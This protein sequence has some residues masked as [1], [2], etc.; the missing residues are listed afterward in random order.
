MGSAQRLEVVMHSPVGQVSRNY[1]ITAGDLSVFS[2]HGNGVGKTTWEERINS[3]DLSQGEHPSFAREML[4]QVLLGYWGELNAFNTVAA[5]TRNVVYEPGPSHGMAASPLSVIYNFGIPVSAQYRD[6]MLDIKQSRIFAIAK[7]AD[8]QATRNYVLNAGHIASYLEAGVLDQAFLRK[9]GHS[10]SSVTAFDLANANGQRLYRIDQNNLDSAL[11]AINADRGVQQD[12]RNAVNAGF[13]ALIHN[14]PIQNEAFSGSGYMLLDPDTGSGAYRISGGRNGGSTA[15]PVGVYPIPE[16]PATPIMGLFLGMAAST[17]NAGLATST[18]GMMTGVAIPLVASPA[19]IALV[20]VAIVLAVLIAI[21]FVDSIDQKYPRTR[22]QLRKY[23]DKAGFIFSMTQEF[24]R[25]SA[26]GTFGPGVYL[27]SLDIDRELNEV[28]CPMSEEEK[29]R[30]AAAYQIPGPDE[31][32]DLSR[33]ERYIDV[34]ITRDNYFPIEYSKNSNGVTE[35][36]IRSPGV[37][38]GIGSFG[39]DLW[40]TCPETFF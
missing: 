22:I 32:P 26:D 20:I 39:V 34:I 38:F 2:I 27:A 25:A 12:I 5:K 31:P 14:E 17:A 10:I 36:V 11:A 37:Y 13:F 23:T 6:R 30:I 16:I 7:G 24:I 33:A 19:A 21:S 40:R 29:E 9:P 1:L 28:G 4:Y 8:A 3:H 35:V 15:A 18:A